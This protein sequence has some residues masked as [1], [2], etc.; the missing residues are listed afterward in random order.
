MPALLEGSDGREARVRNRLWTAGNYILAVLLALMGVPNLAGSL[1]ALRL[2]DSWRVDT[3]L[4]VLNHCTFG[5]RYVW[6]YGPLGFADFPKLVSRHL[7]APAV[8]LQVAL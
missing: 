2:D 3:Y 8:V 5:G 1:G 4:A 6:T 7:L